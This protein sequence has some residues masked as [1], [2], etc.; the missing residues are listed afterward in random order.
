MNLIELD[1][2]HSLVG[3]GHIQMIVVQLLRQR[4]GSAEGVREA[5]RGGPGQSC[6][7]GRHVVTNSKQNR[8]E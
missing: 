6:V 3:R 2:S 7:F 8:L 5:H 4:A 1:M